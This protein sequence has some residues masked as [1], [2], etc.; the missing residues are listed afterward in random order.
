MA[1]TM[2]LMDGRG[3]RQKADLAIAEPMQPIWQITVG[4]VVD[5]VA[6]EEQ[7]VL[8]TLPVLSSLTNLK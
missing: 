8:L 4:V 1:Y 5:M 7:N 2:P 3:Q 6:S